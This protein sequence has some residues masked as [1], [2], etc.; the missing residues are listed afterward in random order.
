MTVLRNILLGI[1]LAAP[2]GPAGIAVIQNG[3]KH[4]FMS[5]FLTGVGVTLADGV[6]LFVVFVGISSFLQLSWVRIL[7][8]CLGA[9]VLLYLGFSSIRSSKASVDFEA[10]AASSARGPL[11]VGFLVNASNP[12]SVVWW[13]GVFGGLLNETAGTIS[14]IQA[15][16]SSATI[17]IGILGWHSGMALLTHWGGRFLNE[18]ALRVIALTAGIALVFFGLRFAFLAGSSLW[19]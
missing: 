10:G 2:L 18:R 4:G 19:E 16:L 1:S 13:V 5:A 8:W 7:I 15:L 3:L 17:L 11:L 12:I 9:G 14:R 6:F